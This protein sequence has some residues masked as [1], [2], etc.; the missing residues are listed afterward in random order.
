MNTMGAIS[1][2]ENALFLELKANKR[3]VHHKTPK[4]LSRTL[5]DDIPESQS[6]EEF[7]LQSYLD[8]LISAADASATFEL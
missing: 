4:M 1:E 5:I 8:V 2:V 7:N 6:R 3:I